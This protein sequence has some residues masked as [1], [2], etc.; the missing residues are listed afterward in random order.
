MMTSI[1]DRAHTALAVNITV[2]AMLRALDAGYD[3]V[4]D[5]RN[6]YGPEW[7]LFSAMAQRHKHKVKWQYVKAKPDEC[8]ER[9]LSA[10][11]STAQCME[12]D[13]LWEVYRSWLEKK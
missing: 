4:L 13:R 7:T 11:G 2:R 5:E 3:V 1:N 6:L 12:I 10:G 8:K 9:C